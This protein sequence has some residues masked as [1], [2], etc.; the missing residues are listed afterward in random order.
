MFRTSILLSFSVLASAGAGTAHAQVPADA[1]RS[2]QETPPPPRISA[3]RDG[4]AFESATGDFRLQVGLLLHADGRFALEDADN[5][6]QNAFIVRRARPYLRGRLG[7]LIEFYVNPDFAGG[8]LVVHDAYV[9]T[10]FSRAFRLRVGKAKTPFG[11]ER[12]QP[13]SNMLFL[14]RAFPTALAPNRDVGIQALGELYGG[15]LGYLAGITNGVP[16]GA[17]TDSET[18][19]SKDVSGRLI[20]RPFAGR[21]ASSR[22]RGLGIGISGGRGRATGAAGLPAFRTQILQQPYF[23]YAGGTTPAVANGVRTRYSPHGWY[24]AGPLSA[25][26]EYVHTTTPVSRGDLSAEVGHDAW[27]AAAG[28]VLT[29]ETATDVGSGVRPR[30]DFDPA[31]GGWG[32]FQLS[33]RY[34]ALIVDADAISLGL[35]APGASRKAEGWTVGLRWYATVNVW[36]TVNFERTVFDDGG[37]G[38]RPREHA[39]VFRTQLG[40]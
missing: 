30:R 38:A 10:V 40:F 3:G 37:E 15:T 20:L 29:G 5:A 21:A 12:L 23:S 16:D 35:A 26:T 11:F 13:A 7:R 34:H 24:F 28:W 2:E 31:Q 33:A 14:E 19:D 22:L 39:L 36:H 18:N 9:D 4:F 17:S 27:Q 6:F 8:T 25:W 1:S 32:A